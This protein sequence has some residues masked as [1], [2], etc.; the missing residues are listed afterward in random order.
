MLRDIK[1]TL[2]DIF[3][4]L[5]P[6]IVLFI[7]LSTIFRTFLFWSE[8]I[9]LINLNFELW[10]LIILASYFLGHMGQALGNIFEKYIFRLNAHFFISR[11]KKNKIPDI[12]TDVVKSKINEIYNLNSD[13]IE[14]KKAR[15]KWLF[16]ICDE[17]ILQYGVIENRELYEYRGGFYRGLTVSFF[18]LFI[19]LCLRMT[20]PEGS[21]RLY[22]WT[23]SMNR[24][25]IV[26]FAAISIIGV[27]LFFYRY[28]KFFRI[29]IRQALLGFLALQIN[30]AIWKSKKKNEVENKEKIRS[31]KDVK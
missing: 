27:I 18:I 31:Q 14:D 10:I 21:I 16:R 30:Q 28:K 12:I 7:A 9:V 19:S 5:L 13:D 11:S 22:E 17:T 25:T 1:V 23:L 6:G 8:S 29:R 24:N 26:T 20:R 15:D 2:Y 3:G 4:Y